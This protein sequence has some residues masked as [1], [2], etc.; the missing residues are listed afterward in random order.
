MT[1]ITTSLAHWSPYLESKWEVAW[2]WGRGA[3]MENSQFSGQMWLPL[4]K[5]LS[6]GAEPLLWIFYVY[7]RMLKLC[8]ELMDKHRDSYLKDQGLHEYSE[9]AFLTDW[10]SH[11][12][13]PQ[14]LVSSLPDW[15][16]CLNEDV[17]AGML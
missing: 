11:I 15:S 17:V 7:E 8:Q 14:L 10:S 12:P 5:S 4:R 9:G 1:R 3:G 16:L 6:R 13:F 2:V